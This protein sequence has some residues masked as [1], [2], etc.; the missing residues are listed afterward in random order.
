LCTAA[1][2]HFNGGGT[3][4]RISRSFM[5]EALGTTPARP[6]PAVPLTEADRQDQN[7]VVDA[8]AQQPAPEP[9]QPAPPAPDVPEVAAPPPTPPKVEAPPPAIPPPG[10]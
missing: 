8:N 6:A 9:E 2:Y 5:A 1:P 3:P 7:A 4:A 10:N